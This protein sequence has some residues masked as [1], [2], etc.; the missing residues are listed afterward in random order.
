MTFFVET[1]TL[2]KKSDGDMPFPDSISISSL[3]GTNGK[4]GSGNAAAIECQPTGIYSLPDPNDCSS[5]YQCDKGILSK[6][7]CTDKRLFDISKREC[8]DFE[9]VFCGARP[10]NP[11]EKNQ[12][13]NKRDGVHP[14][15]ERDCHYYYQCTGQNKVREA[16]CLGDQKFSSFTGRCG[17]ANSAPVPCGTFIPGNT[18]IKS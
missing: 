6:L 16:K 14:D 10:I 5:Y 15:T 8:N 1:T 4:D 3:S 17:P 11:A 13:V 7:N 12:C 18:A 9:R 2:K